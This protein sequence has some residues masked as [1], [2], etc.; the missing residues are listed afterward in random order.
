LQVVPADRS[1]ERVALS[2]E[3]S[4]AIGERLRDARLRHEFTQE[5]LAQASGVAARH[6]QRIEVGSENPRVGT[7]YAMADALGIDVRQ[8]LSD[9]ADPQ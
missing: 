9:A 4:R 1:T 5:S 7:L 6:I 8:L 3:R 2:P